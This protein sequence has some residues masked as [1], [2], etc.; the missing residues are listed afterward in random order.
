MLGFEF[1][2]NYENPS[3]RESTESEKM[4]GDIYLAIKGHSNELPLMHA[5]PTYIVRTLLV[6]HRISV[7]QS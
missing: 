7:N 4:G 6:A 2:N 5:S 1:V 3:T